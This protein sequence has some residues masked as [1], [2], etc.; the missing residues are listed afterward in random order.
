MI[1]SNKVL[2]VVTHLKVE[3][4]G[5]CQMTPIILFGEEF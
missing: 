1:W 5:F 3:L 2:F 4:G